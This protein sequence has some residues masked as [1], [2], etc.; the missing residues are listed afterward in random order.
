MLSHN[1]SNV[2]TGPEFVNSLWLQWTNSDTISLE[3]DPQKKSR[4]FK[5]HGD[6]FPGDILT[7]NHVILPFF[8]H[9]IYKWGF[10]VTF[11]KTSP[12]S[13]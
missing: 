3:E 8:S 7:G 11:R 2:A 13:G 9:E 6:D 10:R 12:M 4:N 5:V 1:C